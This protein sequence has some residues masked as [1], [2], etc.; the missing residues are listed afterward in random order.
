MVEVVDEK[1]L[2][3]CVLNPCWFA[4]LVLVFLDHSLSSVQLRK[5]CHLWNPSS[6]AS[7]VS[8]FSEFKN[9]HGRFVRLHYFKVCCV[10]FHCLNQSVTLFQEEEGKKVR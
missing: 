6:E 9:L 5:I 8:G 7:L 3:Y 1:A 10:A 2:H 4:I